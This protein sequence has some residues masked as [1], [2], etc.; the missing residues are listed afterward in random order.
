MLLLA[1]TSPAPRPW[2]RTAATLDGGYDAVTMDPISDP[3][4]TSSPA[5]APKVVF[6]D[7]EGEGFTPAPEPDV[8]RHAVE[9]DIG[10][11]MPLVT[12]ESAMGVMKDSPNVVF[13]F[14]VEGARGARSIQLGSVY[15]LQNVLHPGDKGNPVRVVQ[16][17]ATSF[18]FLTLPGHFRG[19]DQT[20]RFV[21]V[22]RRGRILLRQE[23]TSSGTTMDWIYD[24]GAQMVSWRFQANNL[25]AALYGGERADF[26]GGLLVGWWL[27]F[28]PVH[29]SPGVW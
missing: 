11:V 20:I 22:E 19:P 2:A 7:D 8:G 15:D 29:R 4:V 16:S 5:I 6:T 25:R 17:D 24:A 21:T 18:T 10:P 23:G 13:P 9:C 28:F 27:E 3:A 14:V 26:P 1:T 12:A